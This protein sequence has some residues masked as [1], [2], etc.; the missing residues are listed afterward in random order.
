[1]GLEA[2]LNKSFV[3]LLTDTS[4]DWA[5]KT[6]ETKKFI[7]VKKLKKVLKKEGKKFIAI[8]G[9]R[10][11]TKEGWWL[12]RASNTQNIIVARCE[13]YIKKNLNKIK[14]NLKKSLKKCGFKTPKFWLLFF[15]YL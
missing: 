9:V 10:Y 15:L 4:V 5:D 8:D 3:A 11:L 12:V 2:T 14:L 7:I 1:M 6:T 13:A